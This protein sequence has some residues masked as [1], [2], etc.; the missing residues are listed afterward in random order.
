MRAPHVA[1]HAV[2]TPVQ[3]PPCDAA[4]ELE[5]LPAPATPEAADARAAYA[6]AAAQRIQPPQQR[7]PLSMMR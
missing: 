3:R 1:M 6:A 7:S 2:V 5:R 4:A